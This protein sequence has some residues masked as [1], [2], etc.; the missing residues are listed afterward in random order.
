MH[1]ESGVDGNDVTSEF[2][3]H[4]LL[5]SHCRKNIVRIIPYLGIHRSEI[6]NAVD[7]MLK[8]LKSIQ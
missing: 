2:F 4:R 6:D 5:V 7:I 1:P 8:S 3:K